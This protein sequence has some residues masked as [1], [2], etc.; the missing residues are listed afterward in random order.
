MTPPFVFRQLPMPT[1][2]SVA[3]AKLPPSC[4]YAKC[5]FGRAGL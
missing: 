1:Q 2:R 5:V 3:C 4:R